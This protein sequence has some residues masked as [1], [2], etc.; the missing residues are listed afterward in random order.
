M[1]YT[2]R[3]VNVERLVS[4]LTYWGA[5]ST[6]QAT[7]YLEHF[8][9]VENAEALID[10]YCKNRLLC[11]LHGDKEVVSIS[12][13]SYLHF[14]EGKEKAIWVYFN[15]L[16]SAMRRKQKPRI[17]TKNEFDGIDFT[18]GNNYYSL[19]YISEDNKV[20]HSILK[21]KHDEAKKYIFVVPTKQRASEIR[22]LSDEDV[23]WINDDETIDKY[24][25]EK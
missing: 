10:T 4:Q 3:N 19:V 14:S 2:T 16:E 11:Y 23:I 1:S 18:I 6:V 8:F 7:Y 13:F 25:G 15:Y 5:F 17:I 20:Y 9:R 22:R 12:N 21:T 24:E